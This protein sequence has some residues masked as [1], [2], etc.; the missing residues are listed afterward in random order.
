MHYKNTSS[1]SLHVKCPCI[2]STS[3][4]VGNHQTAT[5][6]RLVT[7]ITASLSYHCTFTNTCRV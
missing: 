6:S 5:T 4:L 1:T 7:S 2:I 3:A